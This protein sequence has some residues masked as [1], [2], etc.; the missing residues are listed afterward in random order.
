[1]KSLPGLTP[2]KSTSLRRPE[3]LTALQHRHK[4]EA[5]SFTY[6]SRVELPRSSQARASS[7]CQRLRAGSSPRAGRVAWALG[8][9]LAQR[10]GISVPHPLR[11]TLSLHKGRTRTGPDESGRVPTRQCNV[12]RKQA[13]CQDRNV[14]QSQDKRVHKNPLFLRCWNQ[15]GKTNLCILSGPTSRGSDF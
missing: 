10:K 13:S 14:K 7:L 11:S 8:T 6:G 2:S 3:T 5:F 12:Q 15:F 9:V 1:M 4:R